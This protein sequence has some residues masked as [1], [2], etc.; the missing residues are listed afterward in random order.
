MHVA[1]AGTSFPK[2]RVVPTPYLRELFAALS[3]RTSGGLS[4][5]RLSR[6][7]FHRSG[8]AGIRG[9][10]SQGH[11]VAHTVFRQSPV[12]GTLRSVLGRSSQLVCSVDSIWSG[13]REPVTQLQSCLGPWVSRMEANCAWRV[14]HDVPMDPEKA[15]ASGR[16]LTKARP[17]RVYVHGNGKLGLSSNPCGRS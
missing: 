12:A 15:V 13:Q 3:R 11:S 17:G 9:R 5:R 8:I 1:S 14:R 2:K 10:G 7:A 6:A 4:S 16:R